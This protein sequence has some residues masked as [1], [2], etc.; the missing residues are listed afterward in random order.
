MLGASFDL[1]NDDTSD[2]S[3]EIESLSAMSNVPISTTENAVEQTTFS[4]LV[5]NDPPITNQS[6]K[7]VDNLF[8]IEWGLF[9]TEQQALY[10]ALQLLD[11][12]Q[13]L[14]NLF[15]RGNRRLKNFFSRDNTYLALLMAKAD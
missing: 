12:M 8:K 10:E 9:K 1:P 13:L 6:M 2:F 11:Q 15:K 3:G 5:S 4:P 14:E 7:L